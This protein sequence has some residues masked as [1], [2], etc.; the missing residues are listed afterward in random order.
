MQCASTPLKS[1]CRHIAR[2]LACLPPCLPASLPACVTAALSPLPRPL[3]LSLS[4]S[5]SSLPSPSPLLLPTTSTSMQPVP[6]PCYPSPLFFY[7]RYGGY[8]YTEIMLLPLA[9]AAAKV[10]GPRTRL[11]FALQ[12]EMS[13]MVTSY[14]KEH[15]QL[16]TYIKC[17]TY[18][19]AH[20]NARQ[21]GRERGG[22]GSEG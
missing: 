8:S 7:Q 10:L 20:G 18:D 5:P 11:W 9:R 19:R 16:L 2:L 3:S 14:P 22:G 4:L 15:E 12:G 21:G 13:A 1:E 6:H 17:V